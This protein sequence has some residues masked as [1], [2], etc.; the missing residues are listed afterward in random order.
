VYLR[1]RVISCGANTKKQATMKFIGSSVVAMMGS[2]LL[3]STAS[4]QIKTA[5]PATSTDRENRKSWT[6]FTSHTDKF[7]VLMPTA[8]TL[9]QETLLINGQQVLLSYY[10]ARRGQSDYAVLTLAGLNDANWHVAHMLMLDLYCR[11][12]GSFN[13]TFQRET[14][15]DGY[16]GKQFSLESGER[17]GEWRI[18]QVNKTFLAVGGSS[19]STHSQSLKRFFDSFSLSG[20]SSTVANANNA[21]EK[22]VSNSTGRWLIILQTFSRH[23]RARANHTMNRLRAQGY[24]TEV[25]RTDSYPNLRPG[26]LVLAMGPFSKRTAE[27]RLGKLRSVAPQS[28]IKAGW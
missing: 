14:S 20:T 18:Y 22:R 28:Y 2:L 11:T 24:D 3:L 9:K 21:V 13:A 1:I 7:E 15:L 27:Q 8:P 16:A 6:R 19:N 10:G 4:A 26:L 25:I 12:S 23:E 17:V 5:F